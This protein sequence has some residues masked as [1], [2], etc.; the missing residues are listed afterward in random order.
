MRSAYVLIC[1]LVFPQVITALERDVSVTIDLPSPVNT[2]KTYTDLFFI[3]NEDKV[4]GVT[5]D[6]EVF[7]LYLWEFHNY[8]F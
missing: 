4:S 3:R 2:S 5:D 7:K 6:L 1:L 8:F